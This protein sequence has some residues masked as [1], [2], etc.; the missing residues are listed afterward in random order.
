MVGRHAQMIPIDCSIVVQIDT[1]TTVYVKSLESTQS[2][3]TTR[4]IEAVQALP[5]DLAK[6]IWFTKQLDSARY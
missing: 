5:N 4:T 6:Q 2:K 1:G 3:A